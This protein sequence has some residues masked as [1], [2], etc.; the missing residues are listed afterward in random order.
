MMKSIATNKPI[1]TNSLRADLIRNRY[2]Y[3]MVLPVLIY[4]LVFKYAPMFGL[5]MA[6]Q[7]YRP[8]LGIMGSKWVGLKNF[9]SFLSSVYA[10]RT[11][12]NTLLINIYQIIFGFPCPIILAL[13][14]NELRSKRYKKVVQTISYM[15]HFIS[16]MVVCGLL[17]SFC[18]SDGL[19]NVIGSL[20]G[21]E[22]QNYLSNPAAFRTIYVGSSIWQTMGWSSIL[23][24]ATLSN[25]DPNLHE[26]AA[27]DGAGRFRRIWHVTLPALIPVIAIQLIMKFGQIMT[28]G[29]EKVILLYN[30]LT[31]ETADIISSYVYR[32]GLEEMNFSV[33]AA[34]GM[35]NSVVNII[36]LVTANAASNK[37]LHESL[38]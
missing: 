9:T 28:S 3:L 27:I 13:L 30:P 4:Y 18:K 29:Y 21:A 16:V 5:T 23:Y 10:A 6:F 34:V 36:I 26:A 7:N 17:Y 12:R 14:F 37:F 22:R 19:F 31:Y 25:V 38:W 1:R 8:A 35:F 20:F 33:G 24:M 32:R 11:I 15:P 2:V